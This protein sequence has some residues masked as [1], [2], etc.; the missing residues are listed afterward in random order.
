MNRLLLTILLLAL[1]C[2]SAAA[3]KCSPT[4]DS[5]AF[6]AEVISANLFK[7]DSD[8]HLVWACHERD[9]QGHYTSEAL[10]FGCLVGTWGDVDLT[11]LGNRAETVRK[12]ADQ[13]KAFF[14]SWARHVR[15]E[16]DPRCAALI[17]AITKEWY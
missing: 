8:P 17:T 14:E 3:P 4:E 6:T 10:H 13:R 9:A 16:N 7:T 5:A 1:P 15:T 2:L 11:K 12:A